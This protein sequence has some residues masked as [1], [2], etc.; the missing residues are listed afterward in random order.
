MG[1]FLSYW[2]VA[3]VALG[4]PLWKLLPRYGMSKYFAIMSIVP[5]LGFVLL[6]IIAFKDDIDG[7]AA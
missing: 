7:T 2:L 1:D 3:A 6:W 4:V 5:A